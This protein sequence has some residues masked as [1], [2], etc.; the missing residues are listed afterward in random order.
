MSPGH[1]LWVSIIYYI[2]A[3]FI[4]NIRIWVDLLYNN[5]VICESMLL[6]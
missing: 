1:I 3:F 6:V 5:S 2:G 4:A